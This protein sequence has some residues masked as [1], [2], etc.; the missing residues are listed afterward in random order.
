M[1]SIVANV[2]DED[3]VTH[4]LQPRF[5]AL[6]G[7]GPGS[8]ELVETWCKRVGRNLPWSAPTI[9]VLIVQL[10]ADRSSKHGTSSTKE[11]CD[12]VKTW[13]DTGAA[14][15]RLIIAIPAQAIEA[16]LLPLIEPVSPSSEGIPHPAQRLASKG[17]LEPDGHGKPRKDLSQ[18][19]AMA[20]E[21]A[22]RLDGARANLPELDRFMRKL[23]AFA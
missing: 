17:R 8:N 19:R 14:D 7:W 4:Y 13:L 18:Y 16:W 20:E 12:R 10:D 1:E 3:F 5:D 15:P 11:L 22:G 6:H 9:E 2:L 21:L 23:A